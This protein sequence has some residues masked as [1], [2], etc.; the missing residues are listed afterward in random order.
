MLNFRNSNN[1]R[2]WIKWFLG[3]INGFWAQALRPYG[4]CTDRKIIC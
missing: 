3:C 4:E 2:G 1:F